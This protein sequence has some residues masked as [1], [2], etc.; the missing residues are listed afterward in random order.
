M[1]VENRSGFVSRIMSEAWD[2]GLVTGNGT[3]GAILHGTPV[4]HR[5]SLTHERF[6]LPVD[7]PLPPPDV[8]GRLAGYRA[9][10]RK[11]NPKFVGEDVTGAARLEGYPDKMIWTDP[12]VPAGVLGW[13]PDSPTGGDYRRD[14]D[15]CTGVASVSWIT[16][17]GIRYR[18]K[19]FASRADDVVVFD[20]S[21]DGGTLDGTLSLGAGRDAS[22]ARARD[23]RSSVRVS[24][25]ATDE[26]LALR[27]D[28]ERPRPGLVNGVL[29]LV[30][31]QSHDGVVVPAPAMAS[32]SVQVRITEARHVVA[33][34]RIHPYS[35]RPSATAAAREALSELSWDT[36]KLLERH[37][38]VHQELYDRVGL[39]LRE[40]DQ[41]H[42][43]E[44]LL[45][46]GPDNALI[47][48]TFDAGRYAIICSSG[49]LPPTLQGV[50]QGT[51][52]P[53]WSSDY[54]LNGNVQNGAVAALAATTPELLRPLFSLIGAFKQDYEV[55]A[56]RIFGAE[57]YLLPAR[58]TTHGL[59]NHFSGAYPHL[60]WTGTGGWLLRL[61]FDYFSH[62][63]D[64]TFLREWALPFAE[65]IARFYATAL[66]QGEDGTRHF[67]PSYSPE[68]TPAGAATPI[69]ADSTAEVAIA[70]DALRIAVRIGELLD[71]PTERVAEW[72]AL[73]A[74]LPRYRVSDDG[75]LAEWID[76]A[77]PE[78]HAHR[79]ASH[80]YPLFY[81]TDPDFI[82]DPRLR[83]AAAVSIARRTEWR[84]APAES[85]PGNRE[86]AFGLV[87]LGL[88]AAALGDADT[89]LHYARRLSRDYWAPN[90][91]STHD[92]GELFNVDACGGLPA[93]VSA[94][95]LQSSPGCLRVLPALPGAWRR[96]SIRGLSC[97]GGL[98]VPELRWTPHEVEII[99]HA[100]L[101]ARAARRGSP[102]RLDLPWP[103]RPEPGSPLE[104]DGRTWWLHLEDGA[105]AHVR[106]CP[107]RYD[108]PMPDG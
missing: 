52:A 22:T 29:T 69:A 101:R 104:G 84:A 94:M 47:K 82:A 81:E 31:L 9:A 14:V 50:W 93:L 55:N 83:T 54:T 12:L 62:T 27:L 90:M 1:T 68:N 65:Q 3:H 64:L 28:A 53:A 44:D 6:F 48:R 33:L 74:T 92:A 105:T 98:T 85:A 10:I 91:V 80:L 34:V 88:A 107:E 71:V 19:V 77:F 43:S 59:A 57:G 16:E 46:S 39:T 5:I 60:F 42:T 73:A 18:I 13:Q 66:D 72:R 87:Q 108:E 76:P 78:E 40:D 38:T 99:V 49:D 96:G 8:A 7:E 95:L 51:W 35:A 23:H 24:G 32:D 97:R 63:G 100:P 15:F 89:A 21:S 25:E 17:A 11:G 4:L 30:A 106:F 56:R 70:K 2:G 61:A 67:I 41:S 26:V 37:R 103:A 36:A 58:C 102:V 45:A 20:L 86:M 75:A 79:H